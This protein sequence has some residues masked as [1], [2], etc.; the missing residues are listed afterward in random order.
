MKKSLLY[1]LLLLVSFTA[2]GQDVFVKAESPSVVNAGEQFT[3]MW[4]V[5]SGGGEFSAPSF[6]G[7]YKLMGPKTSYSSSTQII[8]G[9]MSNE[10]SYS[11]VYYLQ[12][13]KEGKYVLSPATFTLKG[14]TYSSDSIHIEV[15]LLYTSDAADEEDSVDIG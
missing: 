3:V 11:Y 8:N 12:A 6:N 10:T 4:T 9:K 2:N 14:K 7:F 15:C 1:Y 13:V 5:N